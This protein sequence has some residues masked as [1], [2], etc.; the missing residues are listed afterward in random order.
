MR[1][2]RR[3]Q[4]ALTARPVGDKRNTVRSSPE[5]L[6]SGH[7]AYSLDVFSTIVHARECMSPPVYIPYRVLPALLL[8]Q[9]AFFKTVNHVFDT[10]VEAPPEELSAAASNPISSSSVASE[11]GRTAAAAVA[12]PPVQPPF[13]SSHGSRG[14]LRSHPSLDS[15][16]M[17]DAA[18]TSIMHDV[19]DLPSL[20]LPP[21]S[22]LAAGPLMTHPHAHARSHSH[23]HSHPHSHAH[24]HSALD[25]FDAF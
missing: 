5:H 8:T 7:S 3:G 20:P 19:D 11:G 16:A 21:L 15:E 13:L 10:A 17:V 12:L 1:T 23:S 24:S 9:R 25:I 22:D 14:L 6:T 18:L 4:T 2:S